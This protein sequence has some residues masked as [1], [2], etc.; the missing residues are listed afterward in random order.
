MESGWSIGEG[1][2][3]KNLCFRLHCIPKQGSSVFAIFF[4]VR[5]SNRV[6]ESDVSR[7]Q[8]LTSK[9]Y[10]RTVRINI[11]PMVIGIQM[12]QRELTKTFMMISN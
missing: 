4:R 9:V 5:G 7:R 8:I 10:A 3:Q 11:F 2:G 1:S 6:L 12:N